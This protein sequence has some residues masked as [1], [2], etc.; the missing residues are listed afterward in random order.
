MCRK[1]KNRCGG[2]IYLICF[3]FLLSLA[4][5][6]SASPHP[7]LTWVNNPSDSI[8]VNWWNPSVTGN[9]TVEYGETA[10]YGLT[11]HN[12]TISNFHHVELTA[13]TPGTTYHYRINSSDGTVGS[14]E[15][16]TVPVQYPTSFMFA[17]FGD[18][19]GISGDS[20][21]NHQRH[22]AQCDHMAMI[23]P[24]FVLHLGDMVNE[25]SVE[26]DWV[27]FFNCEQ[28][29]SKSTVIMPIMG[30]H[31]V[32]PGGQPY[33][34]YF[35]LYAE[36]AVVPNNGMAGTGPRTYSFDYGNTHHIV[37]SSYQVNKTDERDWIEAD[38]AA[39]A[40]NPNIDWIFA[41]MHKPV[42]SS[43]PLS[44]VDLDGQRLWVPLFEQH[45]VDIVFGSHWHF[46]ERSYPLKEG[47][48]VSP[49]EGVLYI[50]SALA[51]GPFNCQEPGS[52]YKSLFETYY[53]NKT[54][55]VY[56]TINKR[57]LTGQ[58]V[59]VDDEVVDTFTI[60]KYAPKASNPNPVDGTEDVA[61]NVVLSWSPGADADKHDVYF[62]TNPDDVNNADV[63]DTTGIYRGRQ[64]ANNYTLSEAPN[65]GV[66][67][68]WRIDE[69]QADGKTVHKGPVWSFT[70]GDYFMVDDFENYNALNSIW[71]SWKDGFGYTESA[72]GYHGNGSG[73][74]V[75]T[76][77]GIK[78]GDANSLKLDYNNAGT[79]KNAFD[80][81][82]PVYYSE[83]A[84][85]FDTPQNWTREGVDKL[86]I[87]FKGWPAYVGSFVEDPPGIYTITSS[88]HD[89][90]GNADKFHYAYKPLPGLGEIVAKIE[91][92][93]AVHDWTMA[94]VMIRE[95][96]EPGSPYVAVLFAPNQQSVRV[97]YR[98]ELDGNTS[99]TGDTNNITPPVWVKLLRSR[100]AFTGYYSADG[101]SW[102]QL[103]DAKAIVMSSYV[104][105][106]LALTSHD[107]TKTAKA[108]F[109]NVSIVE[110]P[111][112][113]QDIG[114]ESNAAEQLYVS[115]KDST[116]NETVVANDD[117]NAV[118]LS[119]W[120]E[121]NVELQNF[122]GVDLTSV[123][124]L[125][126][127]VGDK[128]SQNPGGTG[129]VYFD[130]IRLYLPPP[131]PTL[132]S[133]LEKV[134]RQ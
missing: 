102:T 92:V 98:E 66:T 71:L 61:L 30:N 5:N 85:T 31:E 49:D 37:V 132:L 95:T 1:S 108:V 84:R 109:S 25:G 126:L 78:H 87:W 54:A 70:V 104:Y 101:T 105:V 69:V 28:N 39:A 112:T 74:M 23:N 123:K 83:V 129:T 131:T 43:G 103:G 27:Q 41:Y 114:M 35:D 19:R 73:S 89:I 6:A 106:G 120:T 116:G 60:S 26:N 33:Y 86:S 4:G 62:G 127:R 68:Y 38:L 128:D 15:T 7:Y 36:G 133:Y 122:N 42:Y 53:C 46:Y 63:T 88:G 75:H 79:F 17:V 130:D 40:A 80:E 9:S 52:P 13:L 76:D 96:L 50:T 21:P 32:Q 100:K 107:I 12:P 55:A 90:W 44:A 34:Y 118:L 124:E 22:K 48:I 45:G 97:Q 134:F 125:T 65:R 64:N 14:D 58:L 94:G 3:G 16:F 72:P 11:A 56:V 111:W 10:S 110:G 82:V 18:S 99:Q 113:D 93:E 91:S 2:L 47:L 77:S 119:D 29:L 81:V 51:G 8:V 67:Y 117:P 20:T 121:W 24:G 57:V 115:V 59:T